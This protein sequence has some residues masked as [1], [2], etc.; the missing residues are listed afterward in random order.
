[1]E[2]RPG[3]VFIILFLLATAAL[4]GE[5]LSNPGIDFNGRETILSDRDLELIN[6]PPVPEYPA[7]AAEGWTGSC[8]VGVLVAANGEI[9]RVRIIETAGKV[10]ADSAALEVARQTGWNPA[11]EDNAY[12]LRVTLLPFSF[13]P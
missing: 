13:N 9:L 5:C 7:S 11:V 12:V 3:R 6:P 10:E 8:L 2:P 1:M 4:A